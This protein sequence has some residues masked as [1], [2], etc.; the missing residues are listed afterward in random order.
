MGNI[1]TL[2][3]IKLYNVNKN[4]CNGVLSRLYKERDRISLKIDKAISSGN[5]PISLEIAYEVICNE[6]SQICKW[7]DENPGCL[8]E[9]D[10][11]FSYF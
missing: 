7:R 2:D 11:G 1:F 9:G 8:L 5:N 3:A 6:I 4:N 10:P